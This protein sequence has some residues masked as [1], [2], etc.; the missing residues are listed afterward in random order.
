MQYPLANVF[1]IMISVTKTQEHILNH[2]CQ[3]W[4]P[5]ITFEIHLFL[6]CI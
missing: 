3:M 1:I 5:A 6:V 2:Y 4:R